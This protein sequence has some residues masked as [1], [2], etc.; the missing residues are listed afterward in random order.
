MNKILNKFKER[1]AKKLR[2]RCINYIIKSGKRY[3]ED[4][5]IDYYA[6]RLEYYILG[7]PHEDNEEKNN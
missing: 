7:I 4:W 3:P 2:E 6:Q 5:P 1:R